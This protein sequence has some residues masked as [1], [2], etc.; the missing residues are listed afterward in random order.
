MKKKVTLEQL[1]A[2]ALLKFGKIDSVDMVLLMGGIFNTCE[3]VDDKSNYFTLVNGTVVLNE[4]YVNKFYQVD[5]DILLEKL[6]GSIIKEYMDSLDVLEFVL[7]KIKLYGNGGINLDNIKNIFSEKQLDIIDELYEKGYI[8]NYFYEESIY[9]DYMSVKFTKKAEVYLF[10]KDN[11]NII[12]EFINYL[13]KSG[14]NY[15]LLE[16]FLISQDL[17]INIKNILTVENFLLFCST[18]DRDGYYV[19]RENYSR[20]RLKASE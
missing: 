20:A 4:D 10:M 14:Y 19:Q 16:D 8:I 7:R 12:N 6:Q 9:D 15:L 18:Y 5:N 2:G 1:M 11:N 3:L 17:D 13:K